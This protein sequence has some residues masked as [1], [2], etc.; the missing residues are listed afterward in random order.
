MQTHSKR[1]KT[2]YI[3]FIRIYYF[4]KLI[5]NFTDEVVDYIK[6]NEIIPN[7]IITTVFFSQ[8]IRIFFTGLREKEQYTAYLRE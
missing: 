6:Y 2:R 8:K 5:I 4:S 3:I 1:K 7:C